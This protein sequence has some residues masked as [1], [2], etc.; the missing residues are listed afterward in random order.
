MRIND[1]Y[2]ILWREMGLKMQGRRKR[3]NPKRRQLNRVRDDIIEHE[4]EEE[5][6]YI[7]EAFI[8]TRRPHAKMGLTWRGKEQG[9][10]L[11]SISTIIMAVHGRLSYRMSC[12]WNHS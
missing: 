1:H 11:L 3:G 10:F 5:E 4:L 6:V 12:I 9:I 8:D 7:M 2:N